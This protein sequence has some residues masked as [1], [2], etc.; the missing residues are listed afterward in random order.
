[1]LWKIE[2]PENERILSYEK[3]TEEREK[4]LK[5]IENLKT[6]TAEIPLVI[7]GKKVH[8]D[9]KFEVRCPHNHGMILARA[10][11][12][13]EEEI[14]KAIEAAL[15]A[16]EKWSNMGWYHRAAIFMKAAD[17]LSG[18]YRFRHVAAIMLNLSKNPYE[19]EIDLTELIDFW[20][21]NAYY[22][23]FIYEQQPEQGK[24]E[25]NRIDWRPLEGFILAIPPFNFYSIGGNLP[26][27]PAMVGNVVL[28]K[29][30]RSVI[31]ANYLIM[32]LLMEAGLPAG[33]INFVPFSRRYI[34]V[35][36]RNPD[37]AGLHFTGSYESLVSLWKR[38]SENLEIYRNFPR[39]VG[40]TGGK[41]FIVAYPDAN[42]EEVAT[43]I[44]R[45]GFES[46]GQKCSAV[47]RVYIPE[48]LWDKV[49]N[50]LITELKNMKVGAVE[51]FENFMGALITKDALDKAISYIE[52]A[53]EHPEEYEIVYGGGYDESTGWF[54]EPTVIRTSNPYGKL[55]QE[56]IFAPVVT[57]YVY[58][59][60]EYEKILKMCGETSPYA[61]TGSIFAK[62][63]EAITLA[64]KKLRYAAGNFY[65]N[66]KPTGAVVSRQPFGGARH[67]GT[68][69][70]AG[71][72]L[73]LLR[74]LSPRT[75]KETTVP[76]A[77][78]ERPFMF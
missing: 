39:I 57:V 65:I 45:G 7:N 64:E 70:K 19:A 55:M 32:E 63:R 44:L 10:S 34:D 60:E 59:A 14:E 56:E 51:D 75:I 20:R 23:R 36:L 11:L 28:W 31:F 50:I 71:F 62:N 16:H 41:D 47:S 26:T 27:A 3:G 40:E 78:W 8:T 24:M 21:F 77:R 53:R 74:W 13:G 61:L 48:N 72:W 4:L 73:N 68:D 18:P 37:F 25:M 67:S 49:K 1:M 42:P 15:N 43:A 9:E 52:Y 33:V 22:M 29:P 54:M 6:K 76:P 35:V 69:D 12:A 17:M 46:Q 58:S 5:E 2:R 38:I 30:S 66:D